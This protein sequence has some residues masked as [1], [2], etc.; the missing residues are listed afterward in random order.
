MLLSCSWTVLPRWLA[1][2]EIVSLGGKDSVCSHPTAGRAML[3][4]FPRLLC[5]CKHADC[6]VVYKGCDEPIL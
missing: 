1:L 4:I 2:E 6:R 3:G 5:S